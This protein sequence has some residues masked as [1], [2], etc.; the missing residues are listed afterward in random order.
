MDKKPM[1]DEIDKRAL[2]TSSDFRRFLKGQGL[3]YGRSTLI[4]RF[5]KEGV[6]PSPRNPHNGWRIYTGQQMINFAKQIRKF[7]LTTDAF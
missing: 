1:R 5:E 7:V 6:I 4:Y 2:Y 3:P